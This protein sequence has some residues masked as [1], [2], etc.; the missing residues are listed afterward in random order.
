V[1]KKLGTLAA[2]GAVALLA[3]GCGEAPEAATG[4]GSGSAT[5]GASDVKACM[6]SD[7]GGFDDQSFNQS[8]KEGLDA[9]VAELLKD[10]PA[11]GAPAATDTA[12][13]PPVTGGA[14]APTP[15]TPGV[16]TVPAAPAETGGELVGAGAGVA[17]LSAATLAELQT[18][19]AWA[20]HQRRAGVLDEAIRAGRI[21]PAERGKFTSELSAGETAPTGFAAALERDE[22]GTTSLINGLSA[23]FAVSELGADHAGE[24]QAGGAS[25]DAWSTFTSETFDL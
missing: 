2:V 11:E 19:A 15:A 13:V 14:P 3:A 12:T 23:R 10:H 18:D 21:A 7:A 17:T 9:A 25:D 8:G 1:K 6:V 24:T 20:R 4:A 22:A 5:S 16:D